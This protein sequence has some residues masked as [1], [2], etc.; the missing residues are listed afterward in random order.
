MQRVYTSHSKIA[1]SNII[2]IFVTQPR[3]GGTTPETEMLPYFPS[4]HTD[5]GQPH[6]I[7]IQFHKKM[8]VVEIAFHL[9]FGSDE[10][11]EGERAPDAHDTC[12]PIGY[13]CARA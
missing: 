10:V 2:S 6:L 8:T 13:D 5:G 3:E 9:D 7:N 4:H 1:E 12:S 11:R